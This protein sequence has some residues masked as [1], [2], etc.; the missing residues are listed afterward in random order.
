MGRSSFKGYRTTSFSPHAHLARD[1]RQQ[2]ALVVNLA[3]EC[4]T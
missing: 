4:L 3:G 1:L 2:R